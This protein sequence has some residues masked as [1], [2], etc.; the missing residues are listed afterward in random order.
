LINQTHQKKINYYLVIGKK[1]IE[2]KTLKLTYTY[3]PNEI[4]ELSEKELYNK[5]QEE[6]ENLNKRG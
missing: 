3:L 1:E 5:L 6:K 4:K 2:K